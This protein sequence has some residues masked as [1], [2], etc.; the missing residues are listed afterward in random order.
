MSEKKL[1]L[2]VVV[3]G[4]SFYKDIFYKKFLPALRQHFTV[5]VFETKSKNDA[6]SLTYKAVETYAYDV[7]LAAGGDGTL[8]QV[9]NGLLK[10]RE[11]ENPLPTIGVIPMGSGNDFAKTAGLKAKPDQLV[12]LLQNFNP[13]KVNVGRITYQDFSNEKSERYFINVADIGMGP[14]VV[15]GVNDSGRAWGPAV[16]YYKSIIRTFFNYKTMVVHVSANDWQWSG[17]LRSLAV[18]NGKYYGHGLCI[19]PDALPDDDLFQVFIC[20]N[21]SVFDFIRYSQTLKGGKHVR[22]PEILYRE[23]T[24]I[25]LSSEAECLIEGDG[26][27]LGKLPATISLINRKIGFL[28]P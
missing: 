10:D 12:G 19:A 11:N 9:V 23:T 6:I 5:A 3:N 16:A 27:I 14:E 8:H 24:N 1:R 25:S 13:K 18:A 26:E 17:K 28:M 22:I 2:A 21:V 7:I 4:I 20:G 15:K